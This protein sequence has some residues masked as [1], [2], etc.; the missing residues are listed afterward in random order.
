MLKPQNHKLIIAFLGIIVV[1][2][3]LMSFFFLNQ[4]ESHK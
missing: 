3:H 4:T 1:L 2:C